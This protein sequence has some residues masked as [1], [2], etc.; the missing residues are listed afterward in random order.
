MPAKM[1]VKMPTKMPAK[2]P[3]KMNTKMPA[4]M[5]LKMPTKMPGRVT[6]VVLSVTRSQIKNR[7]F[8]T[9]HEVTRTASRCLASQRQLTSETC[10]CN[11]LRQYDG[12]AR[13]DKCYCYNTKLPFLSGISLSKFYSIFKCCLVFQHKRQV[14]IETAVFLHRSQ[15]RFVLLNL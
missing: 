13:L 5:P 3:A 7:T 12:T 2:R 10:F 1:P 14:G 11:K 8:V 4:K 15:I 6:V 9:L